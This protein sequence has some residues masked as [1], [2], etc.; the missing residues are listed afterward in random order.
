MVKVFS[1]R[2]QSDCLP[3]FSSLESNHFCPFSSFKPIDPQLFVITLSFTI[4]YYC[5]TVNMEPA[6]EWDSDDCQ[7]KDPLVYHF[8]NDVLA[9]AARDSSRVKQLLSEGKPPTANAVFAAIFCSNLDALAALL[10]SGFNPDSRSAAAA[11]TY[12]EVQPGWAGGDE[13]PQSL[14]D[15]RSR[16][17]WYA[18]Q[19][20]AYN[21]LYDPDRAQQDVMMHTL[22]DYGP[23]LFAT[24]RQPLL[25]RRIFNFPGKGDISYEQFVHTADFPDQEL[26]YGV[27]SIAHAILEDGA[28]I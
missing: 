24:Y 4:I 16:K 6:N 12:S 19:W 17:E 22:L 23:N 7:W 3:N 14:D 10:A 2:N 8:G 25:E 5:S 18:I 11:D 27:R 28:Y 26:S 9:L 21:F 13:S 15:S 1:D 20:L